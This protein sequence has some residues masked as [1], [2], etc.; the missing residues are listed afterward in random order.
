ML[1]TL[2]LWFG[3]YGFNAGS[4]LPLHAPFRGRI[5]A[6]AA[7]NTTLS[8]GAGCVSALFFNLWLIERMTGEVYF[9]V[10]FAMNGT[11]AALAAITGPCGVVEPWA[12][13]IIGIVAGLV[14]IAGTNLLVALR[15]DDAVDAIPVH[16]GGGLWGIL[17]IGLFGSPRRLYDV[18]GRN[19]HVGWFY[20]WRKG[21]SDATL[22]GAQVVGLLFLFGWLFCTM[23]PFFRWLDWQGWLRSDPLE[24]IVG[25]DTSYHG[26]LV[27]HQD[28]I[29]PE[30]ISAFQKRRLDR[31]AQRR[32]SSF[33]DETNETEGKSDESE[34]IPG[35]PV[36]DEADND[37]NNEALTEAA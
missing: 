1:G 26:G 6:L 31:A 5:C 23:Y 11:L 9:D 29:N 33:K 21:S 13:V 19:E 15:L 18:N 30:Y 22:L 35:L 16:L 34:P 25:L 3:W 14:Y 17:S 27:L 36:A 28:D 10:K 32:R 2:I 8:A 20:S 7:V 12:A 24:E 37:R 4:A